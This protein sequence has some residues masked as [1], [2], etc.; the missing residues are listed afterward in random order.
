MT[1]LAVMV[2]LASGA[3]VTAF[4][5]QTE[6]VLVRLLIQLVVILLASRA[7]GAA[8]RRLGHAQAMGEIFA[9]VVLGPSVFGWLLPDVFHALFPSDGPVILPYFS[10]LGLV[11]ALFLIG[12]AFE[13]GEVARYGRLVQAVA[14]GSL[15]APLAAGW[16][17]GGALWAV[18]PGDGGEVGYRLFL[19]LM[20]AITAIPI[21]GRVLMETGLA[22][23]RVGVLGI[24]VGSTKDLFTWF[25]M[26]V[27]VGIAHPPL[28]AARL[29]GVVG[30]TLALGGLSLTLGRRVLDL[31][32]A[33]FG[34]GDD[35]RP[36]P[37]LV[38]FC[39]GYAFLLAAATAELGVFAIF[40]AFLAGVTV[41]SNRKLAAALTD[42]LNDATFYL[43]LPIFFTSTGL[44][45]DLTALSGDL[46]LWIPV[47]TAVGTLASGGVAAFTSAN[48][49]LSRVEA[50][51][52]GVLVNTPGLMVLIL[53][54][55]GLDQGLIPKALF[56]VMMATAMLRNLATTPVLHWAK[57]RGLPSMRDEPGEAEVA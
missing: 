9:G 24:T 39:L 31:A 14:A 54:N 52:L 55:V 13:F 45:T 16:W 30:G 37:S 8:F 57:A 2:G 27:V 53:L 23:S 25:L 12:M 43:F 46:W 6:Q 49:G 56:S 4:S 40:G 41:S 35:G 51:A 20:M 3:P 42:R 15:V 17:L 36:H 5:S 1:S 50:I 32:E 21:M 22:S 29:A 47:V 11:L 28:D 34:Y 19:G 18:V 33:R 10:H 44:R 7:V 38:A 26:L 48:L